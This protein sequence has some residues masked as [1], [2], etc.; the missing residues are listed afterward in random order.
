MNQTALNLVAIS[1]FIMT[2]SVLLGPLIHLSPTVP[3]VATFAILAIATFDNFSWQ[4][5]GGTIFLDWVAGFSPQHRDRIIHHEAGHFL[6][7]H[8]LNIPVTGYTLSAWEAWKQGQPGQ[9]GV[10]FDDSELVSQ[11]EQGI[12]SAQMLDRYCT[13]WMAGMA[14]ETLVFDHAEGGVDDQNK[15]TGVLA[16]L[17]F[18]QSA[19]LQKQRFHFLQAKTLLQENWSSYQALVQSMQ[20]R[21]SVTD[22]QLVITDTDT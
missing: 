22:C 14:A 5:Q 15:L 10:K 19:C 2:L 16:G 17:G 13:I 6:T 3:A 21:A 20:N 1:I 7:A 4:G 8:L 12:I 18:S 11:L 9:G